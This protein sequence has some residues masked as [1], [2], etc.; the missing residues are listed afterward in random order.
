M[1]MTETRKQADGTQRLLWFSASLFLVCVFGVL[2]QLESHYLS[3]LIFYLIPIA[4]ATWYAGQRAGFVILA[5]S[6]FSWVSDD[7]VSSHSYLRPVVPYWDIATKAI[8]CLVF[9][10]LLYVLK[11]SLTREKD[12]ARIDYLTGIANRRHF[13][14]LSEKE[15]S[16]GNRYNRPTTLAYL[17][18]D[19]FKAINDTFSHR[20]GDKLLQVVAETIQGSIRITDIVAR[21]GGDEFTVLFPETGAIA[22]KIVM[23]RVRRNIREAMDKYKWPVT[24]SIGVITCS[25]KSCSFDALMSL[26]DSVMYAAKKDGKNAIRYEEMA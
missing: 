21:V 1:T 15:I 14:E 4:V 13:F 3:L 8:F 10:R 9:I 26:S 18:V 7:I 20:S 16:R 25:K 24:L 2:D 23:E 17:D 5:I 12:Y 6:I 11:V 22:S 19:N